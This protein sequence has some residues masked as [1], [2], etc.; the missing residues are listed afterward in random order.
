MVAVVDQFFELDSEVV[1]ALSSFGKGSSLQ[2]FSGTASPSIFETTILSLSFS[3]TH[4]KK[5][6]YLLVRLQ[7]HEKDYSTYILVINLHASRL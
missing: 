7:E 3:Y 2:W 6:M 1:G 5:N 4:H